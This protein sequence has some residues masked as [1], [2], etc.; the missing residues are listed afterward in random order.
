M[1]LNSVSKQPEFILTPPPILP[2]IQDKNSKPPISFSHA[3]SATFLSVVALPA[4]IVLFGNNEIF[5]KF[6]PNFITT[7]SKPWS[8]INILEPTPS[9]KIF[10]LFPKFFKKLIKSS[11]LLGLKNA[12][13]F[14]PM[15][16]QLVF[17]KS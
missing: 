17:F 10:S 7:P 6:F 8:F 2:G 9:I 16:N 14:P 1:S 5:E 15:L 4:I 12:L 3:N 13:A 11:K